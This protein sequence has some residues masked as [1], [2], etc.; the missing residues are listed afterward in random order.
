MQITRSF[1][2]DHSAL[3]V[4]LPNRNHQGLDRSS[5]ALKGLS[6]H[7]FAATRM[8]ARR[9]RSPKVDQYGGLVRP[10]EQSFFCM[11]AVTSCE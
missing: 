8:D 9:A 11:R 10:G 5:A 7:P 6:Q 1:F 2:C 3:I 4:L